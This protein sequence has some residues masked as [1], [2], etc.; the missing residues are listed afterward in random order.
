MATTRPRLSDV[1]AR[2]GVS[3]KTVSNVINNYPHVTASTRAKVEAA[4]ADLNYKVN[5]SARSLASGRTGFIA[6]AVPGLD[7]PY[8]A[9]L[10]GHV[11]EAAA[12]HNWTV[13][14]EQTGGDRAPESEVVGGTTPYL[15]DGIVLHPESL[16]S[17]D[18]VERSEGTP[19]VLIGEKS[20]DHVADHVVADNIAAAYD[21]VSH[22]ISTGRHRIALIGIEQQTGFTTSALRYEG[23]VRAI[24]EA[25][26]T[27]DPDLVVLVDRYKRA[28]GAAAIGD[29]MRL[30]E[31][32]D[33]VVCFNDVLA[34]GALSELNRLSIRVPED[35]AV[36]GFDNIEEAPFLVP[37]LTTIA[38]DMR[39]IAENAIAL[40]AN[41]Q[42][43]SEAPP[44]QEI[45]VGYELM[46][47]ESTGG[48]SR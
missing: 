20:L 46:V 40:L 37:P 48:A 41:R 32:P 42:G 35:V 43:S 10:A 17:A 33:A 19:I 25:G 13:L 3:E 29:L 21:L 15:V 2:A 6:F 38:W 24:T 16:T 8:F 30:P 5:L 4:L 11:I 36:A 34:M 23:C 44:Q 28:E 31:P 22:L 47:R 1:A 9:A 45:S 14:I 27:L 26:L 39:A 18:L 12:A 7:N